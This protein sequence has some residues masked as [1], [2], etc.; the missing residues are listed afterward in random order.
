MALRTRDF[1][2]LVRE[3]LPGLLSPSLTDF[4]SRVVFTS[5]QVYY[6]HPRIHYEVWPQRKTGRLEVGLHFEGEREESYNWAEALAARALELQAAL[7]PAMELEAWT[8]SWARL[9]Q[10]LLFI[11]LDQEL[12]E[13]VAQRLADMIRLLQPILEKERARLFLGDVAPVP[14]APGRGRHR[15]HRHRQAPPLAR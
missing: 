2:L 3:I 5:L 7:G 13:A 15:R 6:W 9:H 10:T 1:L 4:R 14:T 11:E 8:P 12:A